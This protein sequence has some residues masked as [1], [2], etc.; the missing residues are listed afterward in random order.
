VLTAAEALDHTPAVPTV[1]HSADRTRDRVARLAR[2][3]RAA[4]EHDRSELGIARATVS[5]DLSQLG[6]ANGRAYLGSGAIVEML[7]RAGLRVSEL[8]DLRLRDVRL[9]P[10]EAAHCPG[11][12]TPRPQPE[13]AKCSTPDLAD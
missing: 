4:A 6:V 9:Q 5:Y 11:S 1:L 8:C 10:R 3:R 7:A 2:R 12:S 13:C